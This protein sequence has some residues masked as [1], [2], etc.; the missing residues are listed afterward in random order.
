MKNQWR[1]IIGLVLVLIVVL[2]AVL[3]SQTVPV[4]FGFAKVSGPFILIILGSAIIG[5]LVGLLTSTTTI[6]KQKK[7]IKELQ[8]TLTSRENDAK[9]LAMA[10]IEKVKAFYE[11]KEKEVEK[12]AYTE[13]K[14]VGSRSESRNK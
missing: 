8:K 11:N 10:E 5:V 1:V 2:F 4:N 13:E 6:W 7:Q 12:E 9:E 14:P 3:N